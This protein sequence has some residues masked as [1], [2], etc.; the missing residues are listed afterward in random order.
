MKICKNYTEFVDY[1]SDLQNS[2]AYL[3]NYDQPLEY[4]CI[5]NFETSH[6][7]LDGSIQNPIIRRELRAEFIYP[8]ELKV[9]FYNTDFEEILK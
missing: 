1:R 5:V 9:L 6:Y 4:P 7:K 8:K 3:Y 2:G